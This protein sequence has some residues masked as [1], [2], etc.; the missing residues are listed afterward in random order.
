MTAA[1]LLLVAVIVFAAAISHGIIGF[2]FG[3]LC[4]AILPWF[5]DLTTAVPLVAVFGVITYGAVLWQE[6]QHLDFPRCLPLVTG[7]LPGLLAGVAFLRSADERWLYLALGLA[8]VSYVGWALYGRREQ[9]EPRASVGI[10]AGALSGA[11]AGAFNIGAPPIIIYLA[12]APWPPGSIRATLQVQ[13]F[14]SGTIQLVLF[15]FS[16]LLKPQ[17]LV[18]NLMLLPAVLLGGVIGSQI[19]RLIDPERY[20]RLLLGALFILGAGFLA[21]AF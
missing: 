16:G 10:L 3:M 19:S 8:I 14:F 5:L 17:T 12:S 1:T 21:R 4:M 18:V 13:L 2:G 6:R 9:R 11:L 20:R 15:W 7:A